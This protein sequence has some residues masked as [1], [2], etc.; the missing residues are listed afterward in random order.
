LD[1]HKSIHN[2]AEVF[3]QDGIV[4]PQGARK[5]LVKLD[6]ADYLVKNRLVRSDLAV[7]AYSVQFSLSLSRET[8]A[9]FL[10]VLL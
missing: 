3:P 2:R 1:V 6:D 8:A 9:E 10:P 5:F 4:F 7:A